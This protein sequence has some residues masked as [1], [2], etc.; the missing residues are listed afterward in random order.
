MN[1]GKIVVGVAL[2]ERLGDDGVQALDEYV[3]QRA[4][5][6]RTDVVNACSERFDARLQNYAAKSEVVDGFAKVIDRLADTK[7][8]LADRL[9]Q[10]RVELLRWSFAFWVGQLLVIAALIGVLLR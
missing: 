2:R 8:E 7:I 1:M 3:E 4:D 6:W 9:A 10:M 5:A